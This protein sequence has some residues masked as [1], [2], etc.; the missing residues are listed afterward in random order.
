MY[1][2]IV[3]KHKKNIVINENE[4]EREKFKNKNNKKG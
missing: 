3:K 1:N 4:K 2:I